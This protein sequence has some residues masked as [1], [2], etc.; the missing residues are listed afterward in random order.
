M[1]KIYLLPMMTSSHY[2]TLT[3]VSV[4]I[5]EEELLFP[6]PGN[7]LS[8]EMEF[9]DSVQ[10]TLFPTQHAAHINLDTLFDFYNVYKARPM[11]GTA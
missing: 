8:L 4:C 2:D 9:E 10:A 6:L 7:T 11:R 5:A 3:C 1:G